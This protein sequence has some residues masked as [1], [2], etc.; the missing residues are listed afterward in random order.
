VKK[1]V[2]LVVLLFLLC[3]ILRGR[4]GADEL[5]TD[6]LIIGAGQGADVASTYYALSHCITYREGGLLGSAN[7]VAVGKVAFSGATL[8][9][10]KELRKSGHKREARWVAIGVGVVGG[11]LAA[12]NLVVARR[13]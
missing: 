10:C 3:L 1:L 7:R 9:L 4:A 11:A 13:H 12:H 8:L 5:A 6:A 2:L